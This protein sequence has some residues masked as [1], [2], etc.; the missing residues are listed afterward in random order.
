MPVRLGVSVS[1]LVPCAS[2][3]SEYS[4]VCILLF[5]YP[6]RVNCVPGRVCSRAG[7]SVASVVS[8]IYLIRI[9]FQHH[10]AVSVSVT[11]Y[12]Q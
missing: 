11:F 5:Q 1:A 3:R 12:R 9:S 6:L 4:V 7:V 2:R 8:V 10:V